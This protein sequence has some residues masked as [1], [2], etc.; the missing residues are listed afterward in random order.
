M[1]KNAK[2]NSANAFFQ[3]R[4]AQFTPS[5]IRANS[6]GTAASLP[7]S[8]LRR[9]PSITKTASRTIPCVREKPLLI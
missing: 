5:V 1:I 2:P 9:W 4:A 7:S 6:S 8:A 3:R